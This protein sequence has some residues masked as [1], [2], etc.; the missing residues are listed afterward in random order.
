MVPVMPAYSGRGVVQHVQYSLTQA[1]CANAALG[2]TFCLAA[3]LQA[4]AVV[5]VSSSWV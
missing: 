5:G 3:A 1:F 2:V 4:L